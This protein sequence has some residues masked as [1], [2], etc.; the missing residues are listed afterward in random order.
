MLPYDEH[1]ICKPITIECNCWVGTQVILLPGVTIGERAVIGAG[2]VISKDV[3]PY[4]VVAG[5]SARIVK[6]RRSDIYHKLADEQ[7]QIMRVF[8]SYDRIKIIKE[9]NKND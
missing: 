9:K 7:Q 4:A 6:Y 8:D 5:N 2:S 3:P 1:V